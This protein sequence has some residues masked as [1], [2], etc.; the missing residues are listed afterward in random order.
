MESMTHFCHCVQADVHLC[1][2]L[3]QQHMVNIRYL[4]IY[5][6]VH[7]LYIFKHAYTHQLYT[8]R[9]TVRS[10]SPVFQWYPLHT[11]PSVPR[12]Y[13]QAISHTLVPGHARMAV[14]S[15]PTLHSWL[16]PCQLQPLAVSLPQASLV[17]CALHLYSIAAIFLANLQRRTGRRA[18]VS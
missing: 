6:L 10:G 9:G 17:L 7:S 11:S 16:Y 15:S 1:N 2:L 5:L 8:P 3:P 4:Y 13:V 12:S 14:H 18:R